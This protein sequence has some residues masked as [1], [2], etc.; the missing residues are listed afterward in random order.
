MVRP[1]KNPADG[2]PRGFWNDTHA[3]VVGSP[4]TPGDTITFQKDSENSAD[5]Y[6]IDVADL[7][8]WL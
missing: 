8:P 7:E 5:F 2:H 1:T 4:I 3:F 6:Y